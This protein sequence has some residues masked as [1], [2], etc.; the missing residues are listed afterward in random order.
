MIDFYVYQKDAKNVI[1]G[2]VREQ[3]CFARNEIAI[4]MP[5]LNFES[6]LVWLSGLVRHLHCIFLKVVIQK[7]Y[8]DGTD[9]NE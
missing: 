5:D 7:R 8:Q 1:K 4:E 9:R 3:L 2:I 6:G